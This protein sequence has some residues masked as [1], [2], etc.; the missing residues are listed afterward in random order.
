VNTLIAGASWGA[1]AVST[2]L[3]WSGGGHR[4]HLRGCFRDALRNVLTDR[5]G[6]ER[7]GHAQCATELPAPLRE[8]EAPEVEVQGRTSTRRPTTWVGLE[9]ETGRTLHHHDT[10]QLG[11]RRT[12]AATNAGAYGHRR[13]P[14]DH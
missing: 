6:V 8:I 3:T 4:T 11:G 5:S 13:R 1:H 2:C 7:G 9:P 12:A 10:Q 14:T